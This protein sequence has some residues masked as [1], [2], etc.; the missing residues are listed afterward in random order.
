[1]RALTRSRQQR[2]FPAL[3]AV[4]LALGVGLASAQAPVPAT[5]IAVVD[6]QRI[7]NESEMF[8]VGR[9]RLTEEFAPRDQSLGL[10][11]ARLRELETRRD[12]E[13]ELL[14]AADA[15]ALRREIETLERSTQRRRSEM[16]AAMNR[17]INEL[18]ETIDRRIQEEIAAYAREQGYDLVLTDGVGFAH[19][20]LDIT[21][22]ILRRVNAR[23]DELRQP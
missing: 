4:A 12:R 22:A 10:E 9:Q 13:I 17:R 3:A 7:I 6:T 1:M 2:R 8:T 23:A 5:R 18:S 16:K 11:E 15:Q 19:P 20:R 14:S 21:D